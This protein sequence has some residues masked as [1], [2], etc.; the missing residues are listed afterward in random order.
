MNEPAAAFPMFFTV[1]LS[2][3]RSEIT[4]SGRPPVVVVVVPVVVVVDVDVEVVVRVGE[5][6]K[7]QAGDCAPSSFVFPRQKARTL[8]EPGPRGVKEPLKLPAGSVAASRTSAEPSGATIA[9]RT[10]APPT[11]GTSVPE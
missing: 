10:G 2:F 9:T 5:T 6:S 8:Y 3:V 4:R 11:V 7:P 1:A